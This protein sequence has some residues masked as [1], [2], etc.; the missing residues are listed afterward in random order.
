MGQV[1]LMAKYKNKAWLK[2][3]YIAKKYS[4]IKI[5]EICGCSGVTIRNWLRRHNI[6]IRSK[7]EAVSGELHPF[8]NKKRPD[9]S[10]RFSGKGNPRYRKSVSKETREKLS[11][12]N[13]GKKHSK[14]TKEKIRQKLVGRPKTE[15]HKKKL[16]IAA[17][18]R[19]AKKENHPM[20][21]K[22]NSWGTHSEE[23]KR[24]ISNRMQGANNPMYG[25]RGP[26]NPM[27]GLKEKD[28]PAWV[29]PEKRRSALYTQIRSCEKGILWRKAVYKRDGYMCQMCKDSRGG[30]L[31]ADHIVPL[32]IL[33]H[34]HNI[35][36]LKEAKAC[37]ALWD[38]ANGRTLCKKC[39]KQTATYAK[40]LKALLALVEEE[41]SH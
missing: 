3:H 41:Y 1:V 28:H 11:K 29:E 8:W 27:W 9:M 17:K 36:S 16:S 23:A 22:E 30:N 15:A 25:K 24:K 12:S 38:I 10:K 26:L 20:Y 5:A 4:S 37:E 35:T 18:K 34:N 6:K 14:T 33:I 21:G 32:A 40:Q 19:F 7:S 39:H 13:T 31:N 2:E